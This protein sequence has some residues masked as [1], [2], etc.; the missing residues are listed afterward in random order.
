MTSVMALQIS[1]NSIT[2][3]L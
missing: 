3:Y 2:S 1:R